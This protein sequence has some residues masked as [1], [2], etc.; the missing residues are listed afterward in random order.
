MGGPD[1]ISGLGPSAYAS[2]TRAANGPHEKSQTQE[3]SEVSGAGRSRLDELKAQM[4]SGAPV[5][6]NQLADAML[7]KGRVIDVQA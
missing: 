1:R 6:L 5:N 3:G 7:R 2:Y 4:Q